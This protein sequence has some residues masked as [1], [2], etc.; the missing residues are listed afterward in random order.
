MKKIYLIALI[1]ILSASIAYALPPIQPEQMIRGTIISGASD[2]NCVFD[3]NIVL[4]TQKT[5]TITAP[6]NAVGLYAISVYNPSTVT[7][8]TVKVQSI[9]TS[10][11]GGTHNPFITSFSIPKSQTVTGTSISSY[12]KF[13]DSAMFIGTSIKLV[14]SNDTALGSGQ[15]FTTSVRIRS[16]K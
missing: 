13:I 3:P 14:I 6:T 5:L 7:D 15:G 1:L 2:P 12:Q 9:E 16:V 4:N 11:G 8:L 10:F